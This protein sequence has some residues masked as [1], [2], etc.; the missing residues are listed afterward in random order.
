[1]TTSVRVEGTDDDE[2][3]AI[4]RAGYGVASEEAG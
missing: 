3:A 2:R 4:A 1:M